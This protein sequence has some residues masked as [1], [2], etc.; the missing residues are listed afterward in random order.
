M[1][2]S[3]IACR[4]EY[5]W[6][7]RYVASPAGS[8]VQLPNSCRVLPFGVAVEAKNDRFC[9]RPRA[10]ALLVNAV[11]CAASSSCPS[12]SSASASAA[13]ASASTLPPRTVLTL[14][15]ASPLWLL[16]ASSTMTAT[17]LPSSRA[18]LAMTGNFCSVVITIFVLVSPSAARSCCEFL[19]IRCSIPRT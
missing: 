9:C 11:R 6:N 3:S 2:P 7:G 16:C 18:S 13:A 5:R 17:R 12:S 8:S 4:I 14:L 1:N 15:A 19:S 10:A